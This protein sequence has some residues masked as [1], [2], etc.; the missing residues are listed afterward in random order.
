MLV[1]QRKPEKVIR[2]TVP[3]EAVVD[4]SIEITVQSNPSADSSPEHRPANNEYKIRTLVDLYRVPPDRLEQCLRTVGH[5][6]QTHQ[7]IARS[8][9]EVEIK[10]E[11][12]YELTWIDD[13]KRDMTI[14]L[15]DGHH[16]ITETITA[17]S[18]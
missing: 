4:G 8:L 10:V 12:L 15:R 5:A 13:G 9:S 16:A 18:R 6:I 2:L 1:L 11:P 14:T 17:E 3:P 7:E